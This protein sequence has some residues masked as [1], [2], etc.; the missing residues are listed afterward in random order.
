MKAKTL[1]IIVAIAVAFKVLIYVVGFE[2]TMTVTAAYWFY[3]KTF[4]PK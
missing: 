2:D 4:A 1:L 3:Q